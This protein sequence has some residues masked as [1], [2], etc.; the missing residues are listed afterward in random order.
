MLVDWARKFSWKV[1]KEGAI[2]VDLLA[3][4]DFSCLWQSLPF[5]S[6]FAHDSIRQI[7]SQWQGWL[8]SGLGSK[9]LAY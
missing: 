4:S 6:E 9:I 7:S 2:G 1:N 8:L 5:A 3:L